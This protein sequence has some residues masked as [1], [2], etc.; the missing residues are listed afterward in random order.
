MAYKIPKKKSNEKYDSYKLT[1]GNKEALELLDGQEIRSLKYEGVIGIEGTNVYREGKII[2]RIKTNKDVED[3]WKEY[4]YDEY[5]TN[6][7]N[8]IREMEGF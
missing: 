5:G 1:K 3:L 8:K 6:D 4:I 2:K 7:M